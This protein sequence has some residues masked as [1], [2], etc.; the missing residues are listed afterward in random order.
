MEADPALQ[1]GLGSALQALADLAIPVSI[2]IAMPLAEQQLGL[3]IEADLLEVY[4]RTDGGAVLE[5]G[6]RWLVLYSHGLWTPPPLTAHT[7]NLFRR[8]SIS[9]RP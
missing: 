8:A 4:R 6:F 7:P 2:K 5:L 9:R 1:R 3:G